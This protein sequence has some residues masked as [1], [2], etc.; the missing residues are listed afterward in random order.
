M[1][2]DSLTLIYIVICDT[3]FLNDEKNKIKCKCASQGSNGGQSSVL[4]KDYVNNND[5]NY[6]N[7]KKSA[8]STK[9]YVYL[10]IPNNYANLVG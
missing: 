8:F 1:P 7:N 3:K 9:K 5:D 4:F 6:N 2:S 10:Y